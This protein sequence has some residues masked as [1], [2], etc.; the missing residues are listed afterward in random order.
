MNKNNTALLIIDF[1]IGSFHKKKSL[2]KSNELLKNIQTLIT[3]ARIKNIPIFLTKHNGKQGSCN[4]KGMPGWSIHPS[5]QLTGDEVIIEKDFPDSFQQTDLES[6][7]ASKNINHIV[8]A[9]IQSEICVDATCRQAFSKGFEV[10]IVEDGHSTF[11]S[12]NLTADQIINHHN[13]IFKKWFSSLLNSNH[14]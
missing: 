12:N 5:I 9:G 4:Q 1:Q 3:Q 7:L 2:F 6:H 14:F 13:E 8:I 11:N 10:T